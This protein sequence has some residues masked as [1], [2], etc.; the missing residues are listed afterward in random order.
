MDGQTSRLKMQD[1]TIRWQQCRVFV[2]VPPPPKVN[3][4]HADLTNLIVETDQNRC[5]KFE[6]QIYALVIGHFQKVGSW[7]VKQVG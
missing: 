7:M 2:L 4:C 1:L 5:V 3:S 6:T